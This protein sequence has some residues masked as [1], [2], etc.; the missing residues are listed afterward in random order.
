M[1]RDTLS[2]ANKKYKAYNLRMSF[3]FTDERE[4]Y[5]HYSP[6]KLS[7]EQHREFFAE[8]LKDLMESR[9]WNIG[10]LADELDVSAKTV[11]QWL[12]PQDYG[13]KRF[14]K[15]E[16]LQNIAD[17]FD[18]SIAWLVGEIDAAGCET[19]NVADYLGLDPDA[20][21]SIQTITSVNDDG[22]HG[23][24][25]RWRELSAL[26]ICL[27]PGT[28]APLK[29]LIEAAW[30]IK[31]V[32]DPNEAIDNKGEAD[33]KARQARFELYSNIDALIRKRFAVPEK[34]AFMTPL[35]KKRWNEKRALIAQQEGK[36][37][38]TPLIEEFQQ[39]V[40]AENKAFE[41]ARTRIVKSLDESAQ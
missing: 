36:Y 35:A 4:A 33:A 32:D 40:E 12:R 10:K 8:R 37:D 23:P 27:E 28:I 6:R 41:Q 1:L 13:E 3:I 20:V 39:G 19:Q 2:S 7:W 14:P 21:S 11:G 18:V 24:E 22:T 25:E 31:P 17:L 29:T 26:L 5:F 34:E 16:H 38:P 9:R 30:N 15:Y